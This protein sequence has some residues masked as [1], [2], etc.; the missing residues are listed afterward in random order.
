MPTPSARS[1]KLD[2]RITPAAKQILQEAAREKHKTISEFVLDTAL[3]AATEVLAER[4][5][6]GL[7]TEQWVKFQAALDAPPRSHARMKRMLTEPTI[8]D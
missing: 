1:S 7:T 2:I 3:T 5:H 4:N 6:L 8:L